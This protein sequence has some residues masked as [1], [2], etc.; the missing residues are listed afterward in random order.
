MTL[1]GLSVVMLDTAMTSKN[2]SSALGLSMAGCLPSGLLTGMSAYAFSEQAIGDKA[3]HTM[4]SKT[5]YTDEPLQIGERVE[6]FL[7]P[8]SKLVKRQK[9]VTVTLELA[10]ES[11]DFFTQLAQKEN[12]EDYEYILQSFIDAYAKEHLQYL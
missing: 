5:D 8:P 4:S 1:T 3:G 10:Q 11:V 6:D 9:T 2:A 12:M 7:P